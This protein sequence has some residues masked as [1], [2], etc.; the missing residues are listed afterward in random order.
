[1]FLYGALASPAI[2]DQ[3][4]WLIPSDPGVPA[5][6][7]D[8]AI[9]SDGQEFSFPGLIRGADVIAGWLLL[10]P[11]ATARLSY[12]A[13]VFDLGKPFAL[14]VEAAGEE[15]MA[16]TY[17]CHP[18]REPW[19]EPEWISR[20]GALMRL[21]VEDALALRGRVNP[22]VLAM[23]RQTVLARAQSRLAAQAGCPADLRRETGSSEVE[24]LETNTSHA[25]F[26]LTRE[27]ALR[28]P[29]FD[30]EMSALL[31][32]EVFVAP[33]AAMVLP[34]DPKRDLVLL[35]EQ[36]RMGSLGRG[37]PRPWILEPVAGFVDAGE[38]PEDAAIRECEEE[39]GL[40]LGAI[41]HISSHYASPGCSTEFFHV[42]LGLCD[43]PDEGIGYGGLACEH[44]DIRIHVIGFERAMS[45]LKSGEANNGPLVLSLL[46]LER[47]RPRLRASA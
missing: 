34:Y 29:R 17:P 18:G 21:A 19:R 10:D 22:E 42:F 41:E 5:V 15:I 14:Q 40:S 33:D 47:E 39:A 37:D 32:R 24:I 44:E 2:L 26:F 46:W 23:R 30:G 7:R 36:I 16:R 28:Y 1:M 12:L 11:E 9:S 43:L 20:A 6:V 4:R 45:L 8:S 3:L 38:R 13:E 31:R 27:Y 25:G 35:V